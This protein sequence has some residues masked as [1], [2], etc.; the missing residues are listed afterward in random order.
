MKF[1]RP[2]RKISWR[3]KLWVTYCIFMTRLGFRKF[4]NLS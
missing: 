1:K 3:V 4:G 2:K